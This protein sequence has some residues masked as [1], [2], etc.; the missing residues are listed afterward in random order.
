MHWIIA[1]V[2]QFS[3]NIYRCGVSI[4]R[5]VGHFAN[6]L[7]NGPAVQSRELVPNTC[8]VYRQLIYFCT[9]SFAFISFPLDSQK[10]PMLNKIHFLL[11]QASLMLRNWFVYIW[12]RFGH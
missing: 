6:Q 3:K 12:R 7:L 5:T 4:S 10:L 11:S 8:F 9:L 2:K 1:A